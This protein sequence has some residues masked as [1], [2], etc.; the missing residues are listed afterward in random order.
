[1]RKTLLTLLIFVIV[2]QIVAWV[3]WYLFDINLFVVLGSGSVIAYYVSR[4]KEVLKK[5][6]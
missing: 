4:K 5:S 2:F 3:V 1:M 6:I